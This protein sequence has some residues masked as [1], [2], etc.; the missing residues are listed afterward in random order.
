MSG[1]I[2][3][4]VLYLNDNFKGGELQLS[5]ELISNTPPRDVKYN[6]ST[7]IKQQRNMLVIMPAWTIHRV[8]PVT[9]GEPRLTL[10][11]HIQ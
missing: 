1:R 8:L 11:G 4:Y 7:I 6:I 3:N 5:D 2:L 10:N 9:S